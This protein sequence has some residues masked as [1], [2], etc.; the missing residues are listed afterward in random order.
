MKAK[1]DAQQP[2]AAKT[3]KAGAASRTKP[4][5][6]KTRSPASA[7]EPT[8]KAS[9]AKVSTPARLTAGETIAKMGSDIGGSV[10]RHTKEALRRTGEAGHAVSDSVTRT[11][12]VAAHKAQVAAKNI[13]KAVDPAALGGAVAG[14]SAG[15]LMG[16]ALG[17]IVGTA[18][19]GPAGTVVGAEVGALTGTSVGVKLGYD[20]TYEVVHNKEVKKKQTLIERIKGIGRTFFRR[21]GDSVGSG[22]GFSSGAVVG[23]AVGGPVGGAIGAVVGETLVGDIVENHAVQIFDSQ[24]EKLARKEAKA[25]AKQEAQEK[26]RIEQKKTGKASNPNNPI[27]WLEGV[28]R[29]TTLETGSSVLLGVVG[30]AVAGPMGRTLGER[31]GLIAAKR[32][33]WEKVAEEEKAELLATAEAVENALE[34]KTETPLPKRPAA[35]KPH[36]KKPAETA[37]QQPDPKPAS[38]GRAT[39]V[40]GKPAATQSVVRT[41]KDRIRKLGVKPESRTS[42]LGNS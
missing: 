5:K 42:N 14:L 3:P 41:P 35:K 28:T 19:A 40:V 21:A 25:K 7:S 37:T 32:V 1:S 15:G 39:P 30:G 4:S 18:V 34:G 27:K 6:A 22:V 9:A 31:A 26:A 2:K 11:A 12:G 29:D 8:P 16:G 23:L 13:A 10:S 24:A 17:G 33:D 20:V 38:K 36:A